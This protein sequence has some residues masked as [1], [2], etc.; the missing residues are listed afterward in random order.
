MEIAQRSQ[1]EER[2]KMQRNKFIFNNK[3]RIENDNF[4]WN[5][6]CMYVCVC[7]LSFVVY[8]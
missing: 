3:Y 6:V 8:I 4:D 2:N 7:E 5:S 1:S